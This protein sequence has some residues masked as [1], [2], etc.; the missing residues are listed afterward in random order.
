MPIAGVMHGVP[1]F[2]DPVRL[3]RRR[4]FSRMRE[5]PRRLLAAVS[6]AL[7]GGIVTGVTAQLFLLP[8]AFVYSWASYVALWALAILLGALI[9]AP[10]LSA[11]LGRFDYSISYHAAAAAL[12]SGQVA[13][14]LE[15]WLR[16]YR[17]LPPGV[18]GLMASVFVVLYVMRFTLTRATAIETASTPHEV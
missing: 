5:R 4:L 11:T 9:G 15:V 14:G 16:F 1:T 18:V 7:F 12:F 17:S 10:F 13:A 6:G 8:F 3:S 2:Q